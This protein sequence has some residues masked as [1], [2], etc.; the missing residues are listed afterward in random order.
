MCQLPAADHATA[1]QSGPAPYR[2][3]RGGIVAR[4]HDDPHPGR[5]TLPYSVWHVRPQRVGETDKP[6]ELEGKSLLIFGQ[7]KTRVDRSRDTQD[8]HALP[9][10]LVQ[11]GA[12]PS[13]LPRVETA[14]GADRL[15][16]PLG[17]CQ[18]LELVVPPP[19]IGHGEK[20]GAQP[21]LPDQR[22]ASIHAIQTTGVQRCLPGN[23]PLHR[24]EGVASTCQKCC[25]DQLNQGPGSSRACRWP[26]GFGRGSQLRDRHSV[27]GQRACLVRAQDGRRSQHLDGGGTAGKHAGLRQPPCTHHHKR[28]QDE[29]EFL[30]QHR[31]AERDAAQHRLQPVAAQEA[32]EQDGEQT[33]GHACRGEISDQ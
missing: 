7:L 25:R 24:V 23:R 19:N 11:G 12:Q 16:C 4:D 17:E 27:F 22:Q 10:H 13:D 29:R 1:R 15:R 9:R 28:T 31:H 32:I 14:Q 8:T 33:G 21:V 30:G 3:R 2:F 5:L 18:T 26:P 20:L 6:Q